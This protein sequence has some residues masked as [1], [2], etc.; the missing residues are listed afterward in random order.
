SPLGVEMIR[1]AGNTSLKPTPL[2]E[3]VPLGLIRVKLKLVEPFSGIETAP[4]NLLIN[5]GATTVI[6]A[7]AVFPVPPSVEVTVTLL[8]LT[9]AVV[10]VT[11]TDTEQ[12]PL[13]A[14]VPPLRLTEEDPATAVAVPLQVLL[15][16]GGVAI[17]RPAGRL[18]MNATPVSAIPPFG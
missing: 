11:F 3:T 18:S 9:P 17:T 13:A 2:S 14:M 12:E 1:P 4:K 15:R 7:L 5:G 6:E 8:F 16:L 10:P